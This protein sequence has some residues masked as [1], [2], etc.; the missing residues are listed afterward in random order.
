MNSLRPIALILC[1]LFVAVMGCRGGAQIYQVK[2][3]PVQTATGKQ[4]SLEDV[5]KAIIT[6]G[7]GLNWQMAVAKPG[8]IIGTLN[9]RS[10]QAVVS[11]PYTTKNY[12]IV[13]KD[14]TNLK[15][16]AEKQ[17]IHENYTGWIQRLDGA[18][19]ARLTAAGM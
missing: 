7:V 4:P 19:R 6:A 16:N 17:T 1:I 9:V 13:Y 10:H 15:Y 18:I 8:E 14:S 12:S 3:A 5:Q 11:I 2:D